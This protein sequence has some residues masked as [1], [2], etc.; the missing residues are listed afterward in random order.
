MMEYSV[1][2]WWKE[3]L[4]AS[5]LV[6]TNI[7]IKFEHIE[8]SEDVD[9]MKVFA[10][11]PKWNGWYVYEENQY[12][13]IMYIHSEHYTKDN[14]I[15]ATFRDM[16]GTTMDL[17]GISPGS[18]KSE[19]IFNMSSIFDGGD[20]FSE[21][22]GFE[23]H[24]FLSKKNGGWVYSGKI[25]RPAN[26]GAFNLESGQTVFSPVSVSENSGWRL[27]VIIGVPITLAILG[28]MG[29]HDLQEP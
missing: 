12:F 6:I 2:C 17:D 4:F 25:T 26:V 3:W 18:D 27:A 5:L 21:K 19:V 13:C 16:K 7:I 9:F 23:L 11:N 22:S 20:K 15:L 29:F 1:S 14:A 24:G 8:C 28:V 10:A